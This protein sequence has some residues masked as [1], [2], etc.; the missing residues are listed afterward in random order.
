MCMV[1]DGVVADNESLP[2]IFSSTSIYIC[3]SKNYWIA[4]LLVLVDFATIKS[5]E[6][7]KLKCLLSYGMTNIKETDEDRNTESWDMNQVF[8]FNIKLFHWGGYDWW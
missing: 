1:R 2:S 3:S 7:P 8:V 4:Y 5:W 6:Q